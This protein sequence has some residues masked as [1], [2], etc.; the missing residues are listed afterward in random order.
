ML[1]NA[2]DCDASALVDTFLEL[3]STHSSSF[4]A[5]A[6]VRVPTMYLTETRQW[7]MAAEFNL[8]TFYDHSGGL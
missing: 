6:G 3:S 4:N 2:M 8:S 5:E 1:Q 7:E